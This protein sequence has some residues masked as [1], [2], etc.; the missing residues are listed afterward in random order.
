MANWPTSGNLPWKRNFPR[1]PRMSRTLLVIGWPCTSG[2]RHL[3]L[4]IEIVAPP[5]LRF[6]RQYRHG[7]LQDRHQ[8]L[9]RRRPGRAGH[10]SAQLLACALSTPTPFGRS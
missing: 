1:V 9:Q 4:E 7:L 3:Q 5:L 10:F 8:P 6:R 2:S